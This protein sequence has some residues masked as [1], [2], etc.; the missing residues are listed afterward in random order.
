M[1]YDDLMQTAFLGFE[2]A[3]RTYEEPHA[4]EVHVFMRV[5][6]YLHTACRIPEKNT[7]KRPRMYSLEC[8]AWRGSDERLIDVIPDDGQYDLP[9]MVYRHDL[10]AA[11]MESLS[12]LPARERTTIVSNCINGVRLV[13]IAQ[14]HG[15]KGKTSAHR[16]KASGLHSLRRDAALQMQYY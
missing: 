15:Y 6:D 1:D 9:D 16:W 14:S 13:D 12:R 4:F 7:R 8:P 2:H 5:R 3:A 11:L 10:H